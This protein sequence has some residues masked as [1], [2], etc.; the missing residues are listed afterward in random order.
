MV[1]ADIITAMRILGLDLGE[2]RVGVAV[3]D[4]LGLTAQPVGTLEITGDRDLLARIGA[5]VREHEISR[6]VVG[7]P[8]NQDGSE[9]PRATRV[10]DLAGRIGATLGL[11]VETVDERF[12]SI[13]A[14]R[15][16]RDAPRKVR[17]Q[18]GSVDRIAAAII[19]QNYLDADSR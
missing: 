2:R 4:S 10:L 14:T 13:E 12:S 8:L 7:L 16:L 18:K 1:G 5:L 11:P 9:G 3:S 17:R 6:V 15:V 19:L